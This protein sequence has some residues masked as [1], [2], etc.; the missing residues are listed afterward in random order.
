MFTPQGVSS[1]VIEQTNPKDPS[2]TEITDLVSYVEMPQENVGVVYYLV[3]TKNTVET[4]GTLVLRKMHESGNIK[5][6]V[7]SDLMNNNRVVQNVNLKFK[8][9]P[10]AEF[11]YSFNYHIPVNILSGQI[12]Y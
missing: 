10:K 12:G 3:N 9:C 6:A 7:I 1:Y 4:L 2:D 5:H 11:L 8:S